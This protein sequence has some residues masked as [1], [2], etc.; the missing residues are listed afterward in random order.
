LG[1]D[2]KV[3]KVRCKICPKIE[4][5]ENNLSLKL[6]SLWKHDNRKKGLIAILNVYK[7]GEFYMNNFFGHAKNEHLYANVRNNIIVD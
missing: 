5:I 2:G 4:R 7:V 6:D 1:L 3:H